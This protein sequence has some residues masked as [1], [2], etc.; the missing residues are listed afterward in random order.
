MQTSQPETEFFSYYLLLG[1]ILAA[2]EATSFRVPVV[3]LNLISQ[4]LLVTLQRKGAGRTVHTD[5]YA[6]SMY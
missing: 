6:S 2:Q 3:R 1:N 5:L 4:D